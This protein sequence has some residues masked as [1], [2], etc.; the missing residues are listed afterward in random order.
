ME[1]NEKVPE[2]GT[3][4]VK[5]GKFE[6]VF[7]DA[8]SGELIVDPPDIHKTAELGDFDVETQ[9]FKIAYR[10]KHEGEEE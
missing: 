7:R 5:T 10:D 8:A 3:Y 1:E 4:N 6:I 2:L 9:E